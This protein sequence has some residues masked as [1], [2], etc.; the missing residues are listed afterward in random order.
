MVNGWICMSA[1]LSISRSFIFYDITFTSTF[2]GNALVWNCLG[3]PLHIWYI[4]LRSII[5]SKPSS[6]LPQKKKRAYPHSKY[7]VKLLQDEVSSL[8]LEVSSMM[9]VVVNE[10]E[11]VPHLHIT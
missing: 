5:L 9:P 11:S 6:G 4:R 1:L 8:V 7:G 2:G 10:Q 3:K